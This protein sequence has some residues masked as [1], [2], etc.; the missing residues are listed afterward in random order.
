VDVIDERLGN[1][2]STASLL[3]FTYVLVGVNNVNLS[4]SAISTED[5]LP[6]LKT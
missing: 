3:N 4:D 2:N 6:F 5:K 1:I